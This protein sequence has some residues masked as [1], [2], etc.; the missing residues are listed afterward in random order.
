MISIFDRRPFECRVAA[1]PPHSVAAL[2]RLQSWGQDGCRLRGVKHAGRDCHPLPLDRHPPEA[3]DGAAGWKSSSAF[4]TMSSAGRGMRD[5]IRVMPARVLCLSR[6]RCQAAVDRRPARRGGDAGCHAQRRT[7]QDAPGPHG[8]ARQLH[9]CKSQ[10]EPSAGGTDHSLRTTALWPSP[11]AEI[12]AS[13]AVW[14]VHDHRRARRGSACF[15]QL[16]FAR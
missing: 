10:V 5:Q 16:R 12:G 14:A 6:C 15:R 9:G 1:S 13:R 4:R 8:P 3:L 2:P 7:R 11:C